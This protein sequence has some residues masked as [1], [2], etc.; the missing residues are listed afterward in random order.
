MTLREGVEAVIAE[1]K[2]QQRRRQHSIADN[3]W[4]SVFRPDT[5]QFSIP[6]VAELERLLGEAKEVIK[7]ERHP[8]EDEK[9]AVNILAQAVRTMRESIGGRR[10]RTPKV[11]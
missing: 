3:A 5:I 11:D 10:A 1:I 7:R 2:K 4:K 6:L 9:I 8:A